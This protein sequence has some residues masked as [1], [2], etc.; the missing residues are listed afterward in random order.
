MRGVDLRALQVLKA[1][2]YYDDREDDST[3]WYKTLVPKYRRLSTE[4]LPQGAKLGFN[5][6]SMTV[7]PANYLP[8]VKK[9]LDSRGV[10]FIRKE[11]DSIET[12]RQLTGCK[13]VVNASGLG[14]FDLADDKNVMPVRGQTMFVQTDIDYLMMWQGSQYTYV[15][16]RMYTGGA[17][18][19]GVSQ[20]GNTDREVDEQLRPD[21]LGRA[22]KMLRTKADSVD[23]A[24]VKK[25]IVAFRPSRKG[26]YRLEIEGDIVHAYGFGSLGYTYCF[27]VAEKVRDLVEGLDKRSGMSKL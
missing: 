9:Q 25:D 10:R 18:V 17:I 2:E 6:L 12:A 20:E 26:G 22:K 13:I 7:N 24:H 4:E 14:A 21:I 23:P 16:P 19:G 8:W 11:I 5:F 27:G 1:T 15:I 3:I